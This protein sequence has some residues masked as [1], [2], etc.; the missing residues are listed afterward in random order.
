M[1]QNIKI[2]LLKIRRTHT[3]LILFVIMIIA[4]LWQLF[5]INS[6]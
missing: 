6:E 5:V 4:S 2:E 1:L 3:F